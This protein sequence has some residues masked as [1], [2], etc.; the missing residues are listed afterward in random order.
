MP[1]PYS[2]EHFNLS[3]TTGDS[4]KTAVV[5]KDGME[6]LKIVYLNLAIAP[7]SVRS[8]TYKLLQQ[9]INNIGK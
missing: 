6:A 8:S 4:G 5:N 7:Y 1:V 9:L 2:I 3:N